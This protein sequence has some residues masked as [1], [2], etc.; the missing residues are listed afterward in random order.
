M[1]TVP[2]TGPSVDCGFLCSQRLSGSSD[3][4]DSALRITAATMQA[5]SW[6]GEAVI[7]RS[8]ARHILP[9]RILTS[10]ISAANQIS[11]SQTGSHRRQ[12]TGRHRATSGDD[13]S[14][15]LALQ[16]APGDVQ[17]LPG[18]GV[19]EQVHL[20]GLPSAW[21]G[22]TMPSWTSTADHLL[23][24]VLVCGSGEMPVVLAG[25]MDDKHA[26]T[27][28]LVTTSWVTKDR[29]DFAQRHSRIRLI[30]FEEIKYLCMEHLGLDVRSRSTAHLSARP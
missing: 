27:G 12:D 11:G 28:I 10:A 29:H 26:T 23:H 17:R 21:Y 13:Q 20:P 14:G 3:S 18:S 4:F 6:S 22:Q 25:V 2:H 7:V 16:A 15:K 30:E 5:T 1:S 19:K 9:S 8:G 24:S